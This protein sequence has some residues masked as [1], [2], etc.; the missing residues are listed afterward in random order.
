MSTARGGTL[1]GARTLA[2]RLE[3]MAAAAGGGG[4]GVLDGEAAAHQIFFVIDLGTL[5]IPE[6]H[7][8]HDDLDAVDVEGLVT[9]G[10]LVEHHP[11]LE[12]GA[13]TALYIDAQPSLRDVGLL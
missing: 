8:V 6:A 4:V 12:P 10:G 3:R 1:A 13:A 11:V 9:V 7:G 2:A 5:E